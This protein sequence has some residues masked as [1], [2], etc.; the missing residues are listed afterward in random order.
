[1]T[2]LKIKHLADNW[3]VLYAGLYQ[4]APK[5]KL[6]QINTLLMGSSKGTLYLFFTTSLLFFK[7]VLKNSWESGVCP[8]STHA[9]A[10]LHSWLKTQ[11]V[12]FSQG[13][14]LALTLALLNFR[15]ATKFNVSLQV[16]KSL[17]TLWIPE[18]RK[19][20]LSPQVK[21]CLRNSY[22]IYHA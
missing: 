3:K 13:W 9:Q 14:T 2:C 4:R 15:D 16:D 7:W 1:M 19:G 22:K 18:Q 20:L 11:V 21:E 6:V 8:F 12:S 17:T 10:C 5:R